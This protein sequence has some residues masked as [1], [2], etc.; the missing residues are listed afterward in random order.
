MFSGLLARN[1][2]DKIVAICAGLAVC[3]GVLLIVDVSGVAARL[4]G[5]VLD[6]CVFGRRIEPAWPLFAAEIG[7]MVALLLL[8]RRRPGTA[9]ALG[10]GWSLLMLAETIADVGA[11]RGNVYFVGEE[12]AFALI[13]LYLAGLFIV[14]GCRP[15]TTPT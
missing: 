2:A 11:Y 7:A 9:S 15:A 5:V 4:P 13:Y 10:I 8:F 12:G 3:S 14:Y 6:D 1:T